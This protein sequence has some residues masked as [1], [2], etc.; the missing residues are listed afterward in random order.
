MTDARQALEAA[1][2]ATI[3]AQNP[4]HGGDIADVTHITLSD[5]RALVL[6]Q[7]R[8]GQPDTTA[9]EARQLRHLAT[10]SALPV[11]D[12]VHQSAGLLVMTHIA[13]AGGH[14]SR[15][16]VDLAQHLARLHG[17]TAN[18]YGLAFGTVLATAPQ[19]N[20]WSGAT[21]WPDFW[22]ERRL[23][24]MARWAM[25]RGGFAAADMALLDALSVRLSGMLPA[26]PPAS[27]LHGDLWPGNI[28]LDGTDVAGFI[29]PAISYGHAETDLAFLAL[30]ATPSA[31]FYCAYAE[32]A[33]VAIDREFYNVRTPLYQLWWLL[34][35]AGAF[36]GRYV[37][38]CRLILQRFN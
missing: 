17:V 23:L 19:P 18:C 25:E 21:G 37:A 35:H 12:V 22:A 1:L 33:G 9:L 26:Q 6:K 30:F 11:P 5:G 14:L 8:D 15:C 31:A 27:L 28:L 34:Y 13:H 10:H 3:V 36:G 29:D 4:L 16:E 2:G 38:S 7:P 24:P 32:A 20:S